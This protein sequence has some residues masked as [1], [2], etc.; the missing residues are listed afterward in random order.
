VLSER[1]ASCKAT[2][3]LEAAG[4]R[5]GD[6]VAPVG[7]MYAFSSGWA[8]T[9]APNVVPWL[10]DMV[11]MCMCDV[12]RCR[13]ESRREIDRLVAVFKQAMWSGKCSQ[14]QWPVSRRVDGWMDEK[15]LRIGWSGSSSRR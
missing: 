5:A 2:E 11:E 10:F 15:A 12:L 6:S 1:G 3:S 8:T 4:V 9:E 14:D 7:S 13:G